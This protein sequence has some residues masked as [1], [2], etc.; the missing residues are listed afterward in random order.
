M[1]MIALFLCLAV[2]PLAYGAFTMDD[3][4]KSITIHENGKPVLVYHY[5]MVD[6]PKLVPAKFRRSCYIH[7]LYGLDGEVMTQD[8][9]LDH[10]HHRGVFWAWPLCKVG[11]KPM[12][13]WAL[14]GVRQVHEKWLARE[15][16]ETAQV[17]VQN[18]WV[19]DDAPDQPKV[20]ETIQFTVRPA[21][22]QSR[23]I[24]FDL[25][26]ENVSGEAV[27][28]LGAKDKGYGGFCF[29]PDAGRKPMTFTAATG[30]LK[31][32]ALRLDTPWADVSYPVKPDGPSSGVA[33]FEHPSVPGY[34]F[35]GWIMRHYSFLGASWPHETSH[36]LK[37]GESFTL[38]YRMLVHRGTAEQANVAELFKKYTAESTTAK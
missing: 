25:K 33:V 38:K 18:V 28:F 16:G 8:F 24:D 32:D 36:M 29:R 20:R 15:A 5:T 37:P 34:P 27:T 3:D 22:A 30:V 6:P 4:G 14:E 7:P 35:P 12:D 19:Y 2:A 10:F 1:R 11:E 31:E 17:G 21:D 23:I 13:V 26:F 9:P